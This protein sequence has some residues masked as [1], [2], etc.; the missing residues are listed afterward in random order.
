MEINKNHSYVLL[1]KTMFL[2]KNLMY[3]KSTEK[4]TSSCREEVENMLF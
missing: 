3:F 1:L 4:Y 2:R